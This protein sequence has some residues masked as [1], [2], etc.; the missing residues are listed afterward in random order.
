VKAGVITAPYTVE[1]RDIDQPS[2]GNPSEETTT[3][4]ID[5]E[6]VRTESAEAEN[7]YALV[8]VKACGICT[9]EQRVYRGVKA[10][11][12]FHGGHEIVGVVERL[13]GNSSTGYRVGDM[14]AVA[15]LPRCGRCD[16]CARGLDNLCEA[17]KTP[18]RRE[19]GM[20]M[21]PGG[22]AE[23]VS[24]PVRYLAKLSSSCSSLRDAVFTE[25]VSCVIHSMRKVKLRS[26]DCIGIF[27]AGTMG[28]LHVLV[29]KASGLQVIVADFDSACRRQAARLGADLVVDPNAANTVS[30]MLEFTENRG[31]DGVFITRGRE[32][33]LSIAAGCVR[34]GAAIVVFASYIPSL[35]VLVD[36]SLIHTKEIAI[37][38]T[39][40]QTLTDFAEAANLISRGITNL[41]ELTTE[42]YSLDR[43]RD[44]LDKSVR[45]HVNRVI[46]KP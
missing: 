23:Y 20:V 1:I 30:Q 36:I 25:P 37:V 11:Y 41:E 38:G 4:M 14:V 24:S 43:I 32:N 44:A 16:L 26:G 17:G 22:F 2:V 33:E 39:T 6:G 19:L 12:P 34:S 8:A 3:G 13:T 7:G 31:M 10:T 40:G 35:S 28:L 18:R 29:G 15:R 9:W 45:F 27:G 5:D 42:E 21:G 46:V